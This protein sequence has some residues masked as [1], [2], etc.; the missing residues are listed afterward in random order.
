MSKSRFDQRSSSGF[1]QVKV[2]IRNQIQDCHSSGAVSSPLMTHRFWWPPTTGL[3]LRNL[4]NNLII[5][6]RS[7]VILLSEVM[8]K[9]LKKTMFLHVSPR[10]VLIDY[11]QEIRSGTIPL[12]AYRLFWWL[13]FVFPPSF[14]PFLLTLFRCRPCFSDELICEFCQSRILPYFR[15]FVCPDVTGVTSQL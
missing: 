2:I 11:W 7:S 14:F 13:N 10:I 3:P 8:Y 1:D 4:E 9:T 15:M 12:M 6:S 5:S